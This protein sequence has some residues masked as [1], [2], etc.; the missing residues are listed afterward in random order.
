MKNRREIMNNYKV[1]NKDI[2]NRLKKIE[3]INNNLK[4]YNKIKEIMKNKINNIKKNLWKKLKKIKEFN[5]RMKVYKKIL[6]NMM[7]I[8][9][10]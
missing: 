8:I 6:E 5:N 2:M 4:G 1:N 9:K 10:E 7:V 3:N